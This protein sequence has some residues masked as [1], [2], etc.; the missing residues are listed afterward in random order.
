MAL[1]HGA[2]L[3]IGLLAP[4]ALIAAAPEVSE[5]TAPGPLGPLAGTMIEARHGAPVALIL[6][7]SGPTDRDGNS[8]QH[9]V[10]PASYRLLAEALA[11]KGISTVRVD[12]RGMF[13]SRAA[14]A[15]AN[16]VT[17]EDYAADV[18]AWVAAIRAR[19]GASCVWLIGHSEGG[20]VALVAAQRPD[21]ICGVILVASPGR[22]LG[23]VLREQ[24][25]ANPA[26]ASILPPALA[27]IDSLE[28]GKRV[29]PAT[30][31]A[32]ILP[33]FHPSVQ[34][35]L[36][37]LFAQDPAALAASLRVPLMIVQGDR[38]IQVRLADA[39]AL[40]AAAPGATLV[41]VPGVTHTLKRMDGEGQAANLATYTNPSLPIAPEIPDA[42]AGFIAGTA[43]ASR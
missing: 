29:D 31:P 14:V 27:A 6:P 41:V 38:D 36:I 20:P 34:G 12:K 18:H 32:P 35:F 25:Q 43:P 7:G 11:A 1:G 39:Q 26:N 22:R 33:L 5:I 8:P 10:M 24:L 30:L 21:G 28:A 23:E 16:A 37:S 13:G 9:G 17:I 19:T 15:D 40:S 4:L 2:R 42:I 3:V